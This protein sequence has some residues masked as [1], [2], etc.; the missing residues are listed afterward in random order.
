MNKIYLNELSLQG[1]FEKLEEFLD[2]SMPVMRCMKYIQ[3]R[4]GKIYKHSGF[5][6]QKITET[7]RVNDLRGVRSDKARRLKSLLLSTVDN[8]PFWDCEENIV[9]DLSAEYMVGGENVTATSIAEA[10][11]TKGMLLSFPHP[12]YIDIT[13]RVKKN[14]T[15]IHEVESAV[16]LEYLAEQLWKRNQIEL[17]DYLYTRFDGTRLNFTKLER[18]YGFEGFE[19]EEIRDCLQTFEKF[20]SYE[21]WNE[22][23]M[24][25]ALHYKKYSPASAEKNW[26]RG[27][28]YDARV[29]EKFRC[30]N[31]KRCFGYREGDIF[32]VL[33]MERDH[34]ISD[35][36]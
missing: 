11:E 27:T 20:I 28:E 14:G 32:Y 33:R 15:D 9:Q 24:D 29:I 30:I 18:K 22:I 36:G 19:K 26:F 10:A 31:P 7:L 21:T 6:N 3:R 17:Y 8:P 5:Y 35:H 16:T 4:Q 25:Q 13:V 23:Y 34:K 1:Q 12:G 2:E